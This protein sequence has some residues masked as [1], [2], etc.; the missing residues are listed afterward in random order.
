M[1]FRLQLGHLPE[2]GDRLGVAPGAI[3][4]VA[5]RRMVG[6]VAGTP[7][8]RPAQRSLRLLPASALGEHVAQQAAGVVVARAERQHALEL[9]DRLLRPP[10]AA[11]DHG[12][13]V[14]R[15][16]PLGVEAQRLDG[17]VARLGGE[18]G[19]PGCPDSAPR[20]P[21]PGPHGRARRRD[22][23]KRPLERLDRLREVVCQLEPLE[24]RAPARVVCERFEIAGGRSAPAGR[25]VRALAGPGPTPGPR[26]PG[27]A[28]GTCRP[29][30][31]R[32]RASRPPMRR[33]ARAARS[34]AAAARRAA[35]SRSPRS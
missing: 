20:A 8:D 2:R 1:S 19:R 24:Q 21:L 33:G 27:A 6:P 14:A 26:R 28:T 23:G 17:G 10:R 29:G 4:Q 16:G 25:C 7:L 30:G 15:G 5:K 32:S 13:R 18:A 34:R 9:F 31:L 12:Q 22:R 3:E 35:P 11:V